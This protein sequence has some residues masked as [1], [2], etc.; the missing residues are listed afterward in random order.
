MSAPLQILVDGEPVSGSWP[1]DRGLQYGDG[2]F[3]TL[4]VRQGRLRFED[5]H[6]A[7][8]TLGC[9]RLAIRADLDRLWQSARTVASTH[10]E[11]TLKLQVTRGDA[12]ARGYTP[13]GTEQA[14]SILSVYAAASPQELPK[15][16]RAA[17][18]PNRLGENPDLAGIKHCNRL[19]QVLARQAL[20]G[21]GAFEG[22]M[23]SSSGLLISGTMS[24]LFL[25]LDGE[26]VTPDVSRC[27]IAGVMRS[28]VIRQARRRGMPLRIAAVP[29]SAL[30][31]CTGLALTNARLGVLLVHELDGRTLD[32]GATLSAL[33]AEVETLEA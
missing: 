20:Q 12:T 27:G 10:R 25:E 9:E 16:V 29:M 2:L 13:S 1:L 31:V 21:S 24:N 11:A 23:A 19:E 18:L 32:G 26:L 4:V 17:T 14:R 22:L 7:R 33:G 5:L 28:V 8:L 30:D 15:L 6:R 3:E